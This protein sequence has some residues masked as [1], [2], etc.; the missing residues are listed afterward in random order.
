MDTV[1]AEM[2]PKRS[3]LVVGSEARRWVNEPDGAMPGGLRWH[4]TAV[5][6]AAEVQQALSTGAF[7]VAAIDVRP[8]ATLWESLM[9]APSPALMAIRSAGEFLPPGLN[10]V[11]RKA[12]RTS[13]VREANRTL[14]LQRLLSAP[15]LARLLGAREQ[16]PAVPAVYL[17]VL[18][19]TSRPDTSAADI[20]EAV[21]ADPGLSIQVLHLVN[22]AFFGLAQRTTSI[23][24]A[25]AYLGVEMIKGLILTSHVLD[26]LKQVDQKGL[27]VE[28]FQT[29]A[30]R[31]ARLA[32]RFVRNPALSDEIFTAAVLHDIGKLL[33]A[34][35][36]P[37]AFQETVRKVSEDGANEKQVEREAFGATHS[38]LG[39][40]FLSGW[41]IPFQVVECVAYHHDPENV[42]GESKEILAVV[43][44]A[45][46]L[47][48]IESL[49]EPAGRLNEAFLEEAGFKAELPRWRELAR[50]HA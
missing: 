10:W 31:V 7:D 48:G 21:E 28:V 26:A 4:L 39:A 45:D 37:A 35:K 46:A 23:Q 12:S 24:H 22:S 40:Y 47:L 50:K 49:K 16:L 18:E 44:G 1:G 25:V 32:R 17:R 6:T 8:G 20:A 19:L 15:A 33:L 27:S 38:E 14:Q 3:L 42:H 2:P 29:Y 13:L 30:L 5:D 34:L 41:G 9:A 11:D 43:H 36:H